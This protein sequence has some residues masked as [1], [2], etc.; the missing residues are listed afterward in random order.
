LQ[1]IAL[2]TSIH[3][4]IHPSIHPCRSIFFLPF[5]TPS[6]SCRYFRQAECDVNDSNVEINGL[7]E[8]LKYDDLGEADR[9]ALLAQLQAAQV[10]LALANDRRRMAAERKAALRAGNQQLLQ[11]LASDEVQQ[12]L[13]READALLAKSVF[14]NAHE[15]EA[16]SAQVRWIPTCDSHKQPPPPPRAHAAAVPCKAPC[17]ITSLCCCSGCDQPMRRWVM[18]IRAY[19][20][21]HSNFGLVVCYTDQIPCALP[22]HSRPTP[23]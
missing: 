22:V 9:T 17:V 8:A 4:S 13:A 2:G 3:L 19:A 12:A 7:E 1:Q 16:E 15:I 6:S 20:R 5:R 23:T 11:R 14:D 21:S 18:S 10:R